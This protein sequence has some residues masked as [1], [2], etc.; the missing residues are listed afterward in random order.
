ML[1]TFTGAVDGAPE[2]Q[3][4]VMNAANGLWYAGTH[5]A[6]EA[7]VV[8]AGDSEFS[9]QNMIIQVKDT[10]GTVLQ[11][12]QM[13]VKCAAP[14]TQGDQFG[15]IKLIGYSDKD[16]CGFGDTKDSAAATTPRNPGDD[17]CDLCEKPMKIMFQYTGNYVLNHNQGTTK[18][19][20]LGNVG[21]MS[22]IHVTVIDDKGNQWY[23][24][25]H[26]IG[27]TIAFASEKDEFPAKN[28]IMKLSNPKDLT[29]EPLQT[30]SINL[31][32][33]VPLVKNDE[34]GSMKLVGGI[35]A[36]ECGFGTFPKDVF[37]IKDFD[38]DNEKKTK[39]VK[40]DKP[41]VADSTGAVDIDF[42]EFDKGDIVTFLDS[43]VNIVAMKRTG[44][45][46]GPLVL[47]TA[48]VF[49]SSAP[50]G[51]S[52]H[53]IQSQTNCTWSLSNLYFS[54]ISYNK[55]AILI[56]DRPMSTLKDLVWVQPAKRASPMR[57]LRILAIF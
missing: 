11:T 30:I 23:A 21:G 12:I 57:T 8:D 25:D 15:S 43:C 37:T 48:M 24:A 38:K 2:V 1:C 14:I 7:F 41:K 35:D 47:G 52:L 51:K 54:L 16:G 36:S 44:S 29:G 19:F 6:N 56:L 17:M 18:A 42:E 34:F 31:S 27:D 49:N 5:S 46:T 32:C 13:N 10:A 45:L 9:H 50:T 33:S 40:T 28:M 39:S 20:V 22:P 3:I 53:R 4:V 55:V 26:V